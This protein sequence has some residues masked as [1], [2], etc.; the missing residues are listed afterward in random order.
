MSN[1]TVLDTDIENLNKY[2][3]NLEEEIRLFFKGNNKLYKKMINLK[4]PNLS[5]Y[6]RSGR[7]MLIHNYIT[8]NQFAHETPTEARRGHTTLTQV[9][10]LIEH[11]E[12]VYE[13]KNCLREYNMGKL[14]DD[15]FF[16]V[17]EAGE[18]YA[19]IRTNK[20]RTCMFGLFT[21][22]EV[23][24]TAYYKHNNRPCTEEEV[25]RWVE[26]LENVGYYKRGGILCK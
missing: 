5:P 7:L 10:S 1:K 12:Y 6:N 23:P 15:D 2:F 8:N 21:R 4:N 19:Y 14:G 13:A 25:D 11:L 24:I 18:V 3:K 16:K 20:D 26:M 17:Y 9:C 22:S